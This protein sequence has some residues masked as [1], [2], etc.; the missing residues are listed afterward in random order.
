[1]VEVCTNKQRGNHSLPYTALAFIAGA[2]VFR[3]ADGAGGA[4]SNLQL[5]T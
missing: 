2:M 5:F 3:L 4:V 1:M